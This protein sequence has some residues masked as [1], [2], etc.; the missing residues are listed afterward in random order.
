MA[1][2]IAS[3]FIVIDEDELLVS[4]IGRIIAGTGGGTSINI[5]ITWQRFLT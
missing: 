2:K 1:I 5:G 4:S 3:L